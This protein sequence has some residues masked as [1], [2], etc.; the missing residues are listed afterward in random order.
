MT[1]VQMARDD[2][3]S[4]NE[5]FDEAERAIFTGKTLSHDCP[6]CGAAIVPGNSCFYC[7]SCGWSSCKEA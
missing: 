4:F 5:F 7:R 6:D 1:L 3:K 2:K